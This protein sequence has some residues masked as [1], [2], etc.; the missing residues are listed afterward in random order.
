MTPGFPRKL[1]VFFM[2]SFGFFPGPKAQDPNVPTL[3]LGLEE[4]GNWTYEIPQGLTEAKNIR[5]RFLSLPGT[6]GYVFSDCQ[7]GPRPSEPGPLQQAYDEMVTYW[8][9]LKDMPPIDPAVIV[10][11]QELKV[12]LDHVTGMLTLA[13][14]PPEGSGIDPAD[15]V[16]LW[17]QPVPTP[18]SN[19][20]AARTWNLEPAVWTQ[21]SSWGG[22]CTA[23]A[24]W[25]PAGAKASDREII[26]VEAYWEGSLIAES[27]LYQSASPPPRPVSEFFS[28][29]CSP[30]GTTATWSDVAKII[31]LEMNLQVVTVF[32]PTIVGTSLV[33]TTETTVPGLPN[34]AGLSFGLSNVVEIGLPSIGGVGPI[35][36]L[37]I[38][39]AYV[40]TMTS[41]VPKVIYGSGAS[42]S[43]ATITLELSTGVQT[44]VA[45]TRAN[46]GRIRFTVPPCFYG[47]ARIIGTSNYFGQN[48]GPGSGS[49]GA[50]PILIQPGPGCVQSGTGF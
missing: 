29:V 15:A 40:F 12:P 31:G 44:V 11:G 25:I 42:G 37:E 47:N 19:A 48:G 30:Y 41:G 18:D 10:E 16:K 23:P 8:P 50:F 4:S 33:G 6:W 38:H 20:S 3:E 49:P 46:W 2:L 45:A 14:T 26:D 7:L 24:L 17:F 5:L 39:H 13:L 1:T 32:D 36:G 34:P 27:T 28:T 35:P 22:H 21:L 43:G 9:A